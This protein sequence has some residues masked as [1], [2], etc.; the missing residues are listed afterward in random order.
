MLKFRTAGVLAPIGIAGVLEAGT[1]G[2]LEV[3]EMGDLREIR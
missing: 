2:A 1:A 3:L